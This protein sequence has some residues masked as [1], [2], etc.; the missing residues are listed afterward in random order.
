MFVTHDQDEAMEVADRVAILNH[1]RIEQ[2][3]S[4]REVA[5][6]PKTEFVQS[7]LA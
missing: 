5:E 2:V 1:G 6:Q 7:F 4:P 3:G